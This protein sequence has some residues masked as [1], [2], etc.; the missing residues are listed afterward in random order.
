MLKPPASRPDA[1]PTPH[2][3]VDPTTGKILVSRLLSQRQITEYKNFYNVSYEANT[4]SDGLVSARASSSSDSIE[5]DSNMQIVSAEPEPELSSMTKAQLAEYA[6][7][8]YDVEVNTTQTKAEM[9]SEI[10]SLKG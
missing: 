3:W 9:I 6:L 2:G 7:S 4:Q 8:T 10:E 5:A 1:V